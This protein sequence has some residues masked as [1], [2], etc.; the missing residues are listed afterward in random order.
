MCMNQSRFEHGIGSFSGQR[1]SL[2]LL[3][4]GILNTGIMNKGCND[5]M[6]TLLEIKMILLNEIF[7]EINFLIKNIQREMKNFGF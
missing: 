1:G 5:F 4:P 7:K 2:W 3:G 6:G